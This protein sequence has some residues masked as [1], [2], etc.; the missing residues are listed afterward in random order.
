VKPDAANPEVAAE[1]PSPTASSR[2]WREAISWFWV[3]LAFFL[4]EATVVQARMIPSGSMENTV[5]VG[6]HLIVSRAGYGAGIPFTRYQV[7]LWREPNRQQIVVFNSVMPNG[8]DLIKRVIGLPG[9]RIRIARGQVFVNGT[10]LNEPYAQHDFMALD[11]AGENYPPRDADL[12]GGGVSAAWAATVS[13][14]ATRG[15]IVVPAGNYFVMGD[16]R[17]D[18]YDSRFWG[19]VP[20]ANII[21]TPVIVY[22]SIDAPGDVWDTGRMG[23]RLGAYLD[24]LR[25][26]SEVRWSRLFHKF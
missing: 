9:D 11:S 3:A 6:D 10:R 23:D 8:P 22:M 4:L 1:A 21:G 25:H 2:F 13:K 7:P 5:L 17:D 14:S 24:A 15:E 26:P 20:R 16:N 19:F 12:L 18:S